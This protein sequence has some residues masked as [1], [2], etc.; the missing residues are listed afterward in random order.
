[1]HK[2]SVTLDAAVTSLFVVVML[3]A[4]P[5][6]VEVPVQNDAVT[7]AATGGGDDRSTEEITA[8]FAAIF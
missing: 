1:M 3:H 6:S 4:I 2:K 5:G 7:A 8:E